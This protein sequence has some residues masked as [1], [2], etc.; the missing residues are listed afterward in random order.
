M[1]VHTSLRCLYTEKPQCDKTQ[2]K[3]GTHTHTYIRTLC[4]ST[5]SVRLLQIVFVMINSFHKPCDFLPLTEIWA[6]MA[7]EG[8]SG[9]STIAGLLGQA[10]A[11]QRIEM[12]Q[13][14]GLIELVVSVSLKL[15]KS[16]KIMNRTSRHTQERMLSEKRQ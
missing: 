8:N 13:K 11:E 3:A 9:W 2:I 7:T 1:H 4:A 10:T 14:S 15:A 16:V 5:C 6:V 12:Q